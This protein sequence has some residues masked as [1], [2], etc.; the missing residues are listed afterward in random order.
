MAGRNPLSIRR[1]LLFRQCMRGFGRE[2][3]MRHQPFTFHSPVVV[4]AKSLGAKSAAPAATE[5]RLQQR[6]QIRS[7]IGFVLMCLLRGPLVC[8]NHV[9]MTTLA[10][11]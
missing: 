10:I 5:K 6:Q 1:A 9:A 3:A 11:S 8:S 4:P 2:A 7:V